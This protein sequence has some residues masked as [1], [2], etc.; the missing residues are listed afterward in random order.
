[1][2]TG[3]FNKFDN[4]KKRFNN[5]NR[6]SNE[7]YEA[8]KA[9]QLEQQKKNLDVIDSISG[10]LNNWLKDEIN[11]RD[12]SQNKRPGRI[13]MKE[14]LN[15]MNNV[16][17]YTADDT[18]AVSQYSYM[19]MELANARNNKY[20]SG[21]RINIRIMYIEE[22]LKTS[23]KKELHSYASEIISKYDTLFHWDEK[24]TAEDYNVLGSDTATKAKE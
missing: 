1:M 12:N 7:E 9:A 22:R 11:D 6:R 19:L 3:K 8:R 14:I 13:S 17:G 5:D 18:K 10:F 23:F 16:K 15:D 24:S 20:V 2:G 21:D 4:N